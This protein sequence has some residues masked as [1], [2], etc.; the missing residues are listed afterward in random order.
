[1]SE[2]DELFDKRKS[3][4]DQ[5]LSITVEQYLDFIA[6]KGSDGPCESCGHR[7]WIYAQEGD[8]P[9]IMATVNVR[10]NWSSNWFFF[11]TCGH[12]A[13]TRLLGAGQIW[14]H[15]FSPETSKNEQ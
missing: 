1:M 14:E 5:T 2:S 6:E 4:G 15:Y 11:M 8:K 9:A 12:C 13:N 10:D 7:E 3:L